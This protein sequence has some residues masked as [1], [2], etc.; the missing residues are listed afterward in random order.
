MP[1]WPSQSE[2]DAYY[3]N[4]RGVNGEPSAGWV[5]ANLVTIPVPYAMVTAWDGQPVKQ[6]RI[7][8][9]CADS[10]GRVLQAIWVASGHNQA[11]IEQ[12]GADKFGGTFAFRTKRG[13]ASLSMHAYG[14]AIDFD[15]ERN[16]L[17]NARG[18]LR[19]C[20]LVIAAFKAENW[21]WGGDWQGRPDP[22]HFQAARV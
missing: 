21:V 10:L 17:G 7:H 9:K 11:V 2:C 13:L 4:P 12:W 8:R 22:M 6:I 18:H 14:C 20:P 1:T 3:G 5:K 16:G 15:P 19:D